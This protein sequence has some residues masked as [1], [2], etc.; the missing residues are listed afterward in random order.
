MKKTVSDESILKYIDNYI[1]EYG[2]AP[3]YREIGHGVGL[4][5]SSSVYER[6]RQLTE[7]G[8]LESDQ[9]NLSR[10]IRSP[11]IKMTLTTSL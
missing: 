8:K 7:C 1:I 5:S 11:R 9:E 2:Y 10:A 6:I 4:S 3:S